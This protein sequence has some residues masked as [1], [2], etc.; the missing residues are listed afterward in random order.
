MNLDEFYDWA[1]ARYLEN[2]PKVKEIV[3]LLE[4]EGE[5]IVNDHIALRTFDLNGI[6]A[7]EIASFFIEQGYS[8]KGEY[9]F[10]AKKVRA[11]HYEK[12]NA[13]K[14]FISELKTDEF[15][16]KIQTLI[17]KIVSQIPDGHEVKHL[18]MKERPWQ[19]SK[20]EYLELAKESEYASWVGAWGFEPNHFTILVNELNKYNDLPTLNTFLKENGIE[21]NTSG[22][23]IKGSAEVFLEQSSTMAEKSMVEFSNGKLEIPSCYYEFAYRH[24]LETGDLFEGFV[25]TSADRIFEST[26]DLGK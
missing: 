3:E 4:A 20:E 9:D 10:P 23:E 24:K 14:V 26:D 21:L 19:I 11:W 13:P 8:E 15:S 5:K 2:T 25:A 16:S 7:Q 12:A 22:G 17:K 6:S 18:F 1:W